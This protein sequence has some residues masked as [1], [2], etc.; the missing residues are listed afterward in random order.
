MPKLAAI[1]LALPLLLS[2]P[3]MPIV[4]AAQTGPAPCTPKRQ[5]ELPLIGD[6]GLMLVAAEINGSPVTMIVDTGAQAEAE[7]AITALTEQAVRAIAEAPVTTTARD[8]LID[9]AYYVA[10]R[11]R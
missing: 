10:W 11:Q 3:D 2:V 8:E 7:E 5:V 6:R 4:I 9:L 1:A